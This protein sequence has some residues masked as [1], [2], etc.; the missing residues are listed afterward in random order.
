MLNTNGR[1]KSTILSTEDATTA[2]LVLGDVPEGQTVDTIIEWRAVSQA[3][4]RMAGL[5]R[6]V[7]TATGG[8]LDFFFS[9]DQLEIHAIEAHGD[10]T[11]ATFEANNA[12]GTELS[13]DVTGVGS[14]GIIKWYLDYKSKLVV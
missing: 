10:L 1:Y 6:I 5:T 7:A 13:I 4:K 14:E 11:T 2:T 3:G 9:G 12:S 8:T